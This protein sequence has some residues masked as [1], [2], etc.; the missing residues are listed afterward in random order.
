[1]KLRNRVYLLSGGVYGKL[2]N[3][4]LVQHQEGYVMIDCGRFD[5]LQTILDNLSYW[6]IQPE[7]ITH[8]FL[9]HG[10][11]D[12]AG[13]SSYFQKCGAS[14][15]VGTG[16]EEMM[17]RG[18]FGDDSPYTNHNM[19]S[20]TPDILFDSDQTLEFKD[21]SV[22]AIRVPGHTNGSMLYHIVMD[23]EE[24]IFSGDFFFADGETGEEA[25][26]GWKGDLAYNREVMGE[27]F[28]K[29]WKLDIHPTFIGGG[30]GTP[31]IGT[32][33]SNILQIAYKYYLLNNR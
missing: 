8:V 10:H 24:L 5:A 4:Y 14:I 18:N 2:G 23:D 15:C 27:S 29:I 20:C 16:D 19:P 7:A 13:S 12:H 28:A 21:M 9:S 32:P 1:M 11:D 17:I 31:I 25:C 6:K 33:A 26:T 22:H 30:H 3:V